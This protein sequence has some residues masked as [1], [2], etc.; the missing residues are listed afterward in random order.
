VSV[1]REIFDIARGFLR[2][3]LNVELVRGPATYNHDGLLSKHNCDFLTDQKFATAY[4]KGVETGSWGKENVQWRAHVVTWAA[5]HGL[6][7]DGDFV[8]CGINKGAMASVIL[9]YAQLHQTS[10][11]FWLLDT[12]NGLSETYLT[13]HEK[14]RGAAHW[15]YE[16]C[17]DFVRRRFEP[18]ANVILVRGEVPGTLPQVTANHVAYLGIDMNCTE[19]EIAAATFFWNKMSSGAIVVLDDYGWSG[20]EDQKRAFDEFAHKRGVEILSLPTGQ[21]LI[22]KP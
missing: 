6:H 11:K 9:H 10:R 22:L 14:Q 19:P 1:R 12:F 18:F 4:A 15:G 8:E 3:T 16:E 13:E 5:Q 2:R 7:L 20:H 21:G 17:F